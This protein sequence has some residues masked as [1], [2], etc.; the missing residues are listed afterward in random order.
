MH[1]IMVKRLGHNV[2]ILEQHPSSAR[3]GQAAGISAGA[4][5]QQ[6]LERYDLVT[7]PCCVSASA[8]QVLDSK[9]NVLECRKMPW[10][11][12]TWT[13]LHHRLRANF[14]GFS[15]VY[16]P[17]P[18]KLPSGDGEGIYDIGKRVTGVSYC[19]GVVVLEFEDVINGGE[20]KLHADFV[21]A[22]DGSRSTIRELLCPEVRSPYAGYLTWRAT[23]PENSVSEETQ[24]AFDDRSTSYRM[25]RTYII[26]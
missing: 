13:T 15:S 17:K 22:A 26:V 21:I 3:D 8:L 12:T 20:G 23:I 14:D 16:V 18:P 25:D 24:R 4:Q 19:D 5:V 2:R 10:K 7:D 9:F 1:G 6:F 11:M